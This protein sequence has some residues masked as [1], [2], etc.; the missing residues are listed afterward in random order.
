[1]RTSL[2]LTLVTISAAV[3]LAACNVTGAPPP[4]PISYGP[5]D[6]GVSKLAPTAIIQTAE[7]K[8]VRAP[9]LHLD[10]DDRQGRNDV[11]IDAT[12][13]RGGNSQGVL[14]VN[15]KDLDFLC[16]GGHFYVQDNPVHPMLAATVDEA[17]GD[18]W[19]SLSTNDKPL[20]AF[21]AMISTFQPSILFK[22]DP[23]GDARALKGTRVT[24]DG[25]LAL[26]LRVADGAGITTA[27]VATTGI[28][29]IVHMTYLHTSGAAKGEKVTLRFNQFGMP[30]TVSKPSAADVLVVP[31]Y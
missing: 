9:S 16:V 31:G 26:P 7:S 4:P 3:A 10:V 12:V 21:V 19:L 27:Y 17:L 14:G 30:V 2:G 13:V 8:A 28:P 5:V 11:T 24:I 18:R 1:M 20:R 6:N 22:D 15:G 29:Y 25:Q 23:A